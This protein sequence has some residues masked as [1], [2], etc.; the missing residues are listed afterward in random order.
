E[1]FSRNAHPLINDLKRP[2]DDLGPTIHDLGNLSPDLTHL[3]H[4]LNPLVRAGKTSV[5]DL[6]KVFH[7]IG[8]VIDALHPFLQQLNPI[9]SYLNFH[10]TTV[11]GFLQNGAP[12]TSGHA[13]GNRYQTNVGI[14]EPASFNRWLKR[15]DQE[16]GNAYMAPNA[17]QR[18]IALGTIESFDCN[19]SGGPVKDPVDAESTPPP[20]QNAMKRPPCF[21]QPASLFG[22]KQFTIP[23]K[24]VAPKR[25]RPGFRQGSDGTAVDPHPGDPLH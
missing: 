15:P 4:N 7:E 2:A 25:D 9:L 11:A 17:L 6:K 8:P 24:G 19:P 12:D 1:T 21:V 3:F 18:A 16:R 10:Q 22:G 23:Q 20:A 14:I 5:P 13:G